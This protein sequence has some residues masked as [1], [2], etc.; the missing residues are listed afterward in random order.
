MTTVRVRALPQVARRVPAA[1]LVEGALT[2]RRLPSAMTTFVVEHPEA[3]F[4][5]DPGFCRDAHLR[6][7]PEL[8]TV[9]RPL[10]TPPRSTISTAEGLELRPLRRTPDFAL[11][12]HAHWD[13]V[14][15]LHDLTDLPVRLHRVEREWV[16]TGT[17]PPVGGV[18]GALTDGR[19]VLDYE[20]DGPPVSTFTSSH[21]LFGDG[22]VMIVDL[23]GHTPGSVGVLARTS[24]GPVLLAGDAAW[25]AEQVER[26]RQ[27]PSIPG[28]F[29]D[30]DRDAAFATLHRLHLARHALRVIP[31]HD[32]DAVDGL[33]G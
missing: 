10:I 14:C 28:E 1:G 23:A 5:V 21:D 3:T 9:L 4:L 16:L 17:D 29:V 32:H 7:L 25:H 33:C 18:R 19:P 27:K 2:F 15:G 12:T 31:T 30:A 24:S 11:P 6:V 22:S 20:L 8:P 13:H 26:L